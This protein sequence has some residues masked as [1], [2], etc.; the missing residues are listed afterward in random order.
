MAWIIEKQDDEFRIFSDKTLVTI[1]YDSTLHS[2]SHAKLI[3]A[4]PEM[5]QTLK[6]IAADFDENSPSD[7][8]RIVNNTINKA[9][10]VK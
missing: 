7:Y 1:V 3:A 5:L 10:G 2:E 9:T 6:L 4:A 8:V